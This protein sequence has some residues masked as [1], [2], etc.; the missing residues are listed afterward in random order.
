MVYLVAALAGFVVGYILCLV[1]HERPAKGTLIK[2]GDIWRLEIND[3]LEK[4]D[5]KK[6]IIFNVSNDKEVNDL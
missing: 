3:P 1:I 6:R 5:K 4:L 2:S